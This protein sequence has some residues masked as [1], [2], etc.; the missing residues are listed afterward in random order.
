VPTVL[1]AE[2][3]RFF[4]YAK[5]CQEPMHVHVTR[6][7]GLAKIWLES[8]T[9]AKSVGF[10]HHE[11]TRILKILKENQALVIARWRKFCGD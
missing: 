1:R 4:F 2:G 10:Q 3:Y 6:S 8:L 5:D 11:E 7:N 9:I